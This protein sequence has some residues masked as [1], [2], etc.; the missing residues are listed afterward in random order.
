MRRRRNTAVSPAGG[1]LL[2]LQM[3][4]VPGAARYRSASIVLHWLMFVLIACAYAFME[5]RGQFPRGAE[6]D[7]VKALHYSFGLLVFV[8]V[9]ARIAL[10][11]TETVRPIDPPLHPMVKL[12][13]NG[14]HLS[15][16]AFMIVMPVLGWA[17]LSAKGA[18]IALLGLALPPLIAEDRELAYRLGD[19]HEWI[20]KAGYFLIALHIVAGLAHH[21]VRRDDTVTGILP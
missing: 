5:F 11:L 14:L 7:A 21:F 2:G 16:Y 20:G 4:R 1:V 3:S 13:A 6:R 18:S 10:R 9:W 19:L 15:L 17:Q 8:L 12:A